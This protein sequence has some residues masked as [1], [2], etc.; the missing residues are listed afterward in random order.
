MARSTHPIADGSSAKR[1]R[2]ARAPTAETARSRS[3]P[4]A[5]FFPLPVTAKSGSVLSPRFQTS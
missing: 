1:R 4:R 5:T 2:P 3:W